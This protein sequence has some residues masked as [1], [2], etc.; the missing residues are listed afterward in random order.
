MGQRWSLVVAGCVLLAGGVRA[1]EFEDLAGWQRIDSRYCTIWLDPSLEAKQV[2][3]RISTWLLRPQVK[4]DKSDPQETQLAAKC[5]TLFHRAQELLD[6]YPPGI[7][8][9]VKVA[10]AREQI[11]T[12]HA[13]RYGY[14]TEA[15]AFYVVENNTIYA[16]MGDVSESVLAHE[17]AHCIIDHYF[18]ARPPRKIEEL[19]A[20]YVDE[21]VFS[22][23]SGPE[24]HV[25][26]W[27]TPVNAVAKL[28]TANKDVLIAAHA[29]A[30]H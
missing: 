16:A 2:N 15:I 28:A 27:N 8:V 3:R 26:R 18:R 30:D 7:H 1:G 20:M 21:H 10:R 29:A 13:A 6:M 25:G 12:I 23:I 17:M 5:D 22:G 4:L 14:G 11:T 19:L 24:G 9:T